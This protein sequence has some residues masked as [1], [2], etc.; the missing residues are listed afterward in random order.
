[1]SDKVVLTMVLPNCEKDFELP[2]T[3]PLRELY[4]RMLVVL[5]RMFPEDY[6]KCSGITF[7]NET[8]LLDDPDVSLAGCG[9][10]T[11]CRLSV[12]CKR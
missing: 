3:I 1:M 10:R 9:V 8:G 4:P 2:A 6:A 7:R 12:I 11:G 5:S